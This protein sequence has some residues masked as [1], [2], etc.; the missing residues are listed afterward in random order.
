VRAAALAAALALV[1]A[2]PASSACVRVPPRHVGGTQVYADSFGGKCFVSVHPNNAVNLVYR[3]YTFY[4]TGLLM[5]FSSYGPGED[6]SRLTSARE[7]YFFPR[8]QE[9]VLDPAAGVVA[10]TGVDGRRVDFD[11]ATAQIA[12]LDGDVSVSPVVDPSVRGG[13]EITRYAGLLLD[14]GYR[15]GGQPTGRKNNNSTFRAP[16]GQTCTVQNSEL[17]AYTPDGEFEFKFDDAA[18]KAFLQTR[19][20]QLPALW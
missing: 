12:A 17:F 19:C 5:A 13:V 20:P 11:A 3:S 18:L 15:Q 4:S 2:V 16:Q 7:F 8:R 10:V 6:V 9:P 14:A 1:S